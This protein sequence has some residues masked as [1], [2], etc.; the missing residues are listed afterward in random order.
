[1]SKFKEKN[2][3]IKENI[4]DIIKNPIDKIEYVANE[5]SS[6]FF[7]IAIVLILFWMTMLFI[8]SYYYTIRY[9][10]VA[11]IFKDILSVLKTILAP[12]IGIVVSAVIVLVLNK[13]NRK[14][15]AT[16]ISTL[17]FAKIP[18]I[19]TSIFALITI[20]SKNLITIVALIESLCLIISSV[21]EYFAF[22]KLF[23]EES[24]KV[25]FGKYIL[26]RLI[27]T[28]VSIIVMLL[29]IGI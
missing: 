20:I 17:T 25:F 5:S 16:I 11:R 3:E 6:R 10:G 28:G 23:G 9:W 15:F 8:G 4:I 19:I 14:S 1:M 26:I 13:N 7:K 2:K 12:V 18:V 24:D 22:K 29:G 21:L 27:Y